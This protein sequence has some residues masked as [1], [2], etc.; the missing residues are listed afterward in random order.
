MPG[1]LLGPRGKFVYLADDGTTYSVTTD[2]S[3]AVAGLGVGAGAPAA[4]DPQ[5]PPTGYGGRFPRGARPR[6]VFA[7]DSNGNRKQLVAFDPTANLYE[8]NLS[9]AVT[10]DNGAFVTTGR[11]GETYTF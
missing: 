8:T 1:N 10:I 11:R 2:S 4:F 5:N 3:L 7:Q 6:V 9:Q